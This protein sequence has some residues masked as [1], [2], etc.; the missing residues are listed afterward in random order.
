MGKKKNNVIT[1]DSEPHVYI[2]RV[3]GGTFYW[4]TLIEQQ[5]SKLRQ[6]PVDNKLT[7]LFWYEVKFLLAWS[8][9]MYVRC[10]LVEIETF[11]TSSRGTIARKLQYR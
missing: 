7:G 9:A 1:A 3:G 11:A 4:R 8:E 2:H 10:T 6:A 5:K